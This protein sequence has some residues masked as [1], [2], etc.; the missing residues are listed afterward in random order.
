MRVIMCDVFDDVKVTTY[1]DDGPVDGPPLIYETMIFGGSL[2]GMSWRYTDYPEYVHAE[3]IRK[4]GKGR[5]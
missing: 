2:D 5:P 4:A 1:M 3:A